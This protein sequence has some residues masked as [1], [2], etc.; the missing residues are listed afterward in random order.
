MLPLL[1]VFCFPFLVSADEVFGCRGM[2]CEKRP[3]RVHVDYDKGKIL[4]IFWDLIMLWIAEFLGDFLTE[5]NFDFN[6]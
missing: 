3:E 4:V 2:E 5:F 1:L 6:T